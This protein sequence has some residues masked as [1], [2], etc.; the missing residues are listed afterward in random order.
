[1]VC[2]YP[3]IK[4]AINQ[5]VLKMQLLKNSKE[6][7]AIIKESDLKIIDKVL[8][9]FTP[10]GIEYDDL[11]NEQQDLLVDCDVIM[12]SLWKQIKEDKNQEVN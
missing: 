9:T 4:T 7:Y 2:G 3:Y 6:N 5:E 1:M 8:N 11:N 12:M 10:Y